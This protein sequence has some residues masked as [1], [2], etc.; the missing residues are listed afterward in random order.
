MSEGFGV[1]ARIYTKNLCQ[2]EEQM[3]RLYCYLKDI[4]F[5]F[6]WQLMFIML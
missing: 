1:K 4:F 5:C 3:L 2:L 6:Y